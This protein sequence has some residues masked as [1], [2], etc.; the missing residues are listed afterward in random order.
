MRELLYCK[1]ISFKYSSNFVLN[2]VNFSIYQGDFLVLVGPNGGGKSTLVKIILGLLKPTTGKLVYPNKDL[3]D[4][5]TLVGYLPQDVNFNKDFPIQS[6]DIV[7]M[8]FMKK[9]I[10]GFKCD[11]DSIN[12]ALLIM[13]TLS[14]RNIAYEKFYNLSGG[15]RQKVLIARALCGDPKLIVFDEPTSN[16]DLPTQKAI[17]KLLK[18][19]NINHTIIVVTHDSSTL[20]QYASNVLL[21]NGEVSKYN[22]NNALLDDKCSNF[23]LKSKF[24]V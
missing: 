9:S 24:V 8:G 3:F 18:Q 20:I 1:D 17:F 21:V 16:I 12:K 7:L 19:L 15:Q 22:P 13:D 6:L 14:I 11:K 10:F 5:N 4:K 23:L 2:K